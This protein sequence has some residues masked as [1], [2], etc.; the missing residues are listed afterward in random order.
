MSDMRCERVKALGRM[1]NVKCR[2]KRK[3]VGVVGDHW[4]MVTESPLNDFRMT[5]GAFDGASPR[6]LEK[7][8]FRFMAT[9]V[10]SAKERCGELE[11]I[12][13]RRSSVSSA[14]RFKP[15]RQGAVLGGVVRN[16]S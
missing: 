3:Y 14:G 10:L 8:D 1:F 11:R 6:V 15:A 7:K 12:A 13:S 4:W 16:G 9:A 2:L 5:V